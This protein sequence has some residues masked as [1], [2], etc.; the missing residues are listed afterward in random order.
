MS[1]DV[2]V[3]VFESIYVCFLCIC[4]YFYVFVIF[5]CRLPLSMVPANGN[6]FAFCIDFALI[7]TKLGFWGII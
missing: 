3:C 2:C 6:S 1:V 7:N 4:F 5:L